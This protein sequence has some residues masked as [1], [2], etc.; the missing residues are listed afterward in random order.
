M[1]VEAA[2]DAIVGKLPHYLIAHFVCMAMHVLQ[3]SITSCDS[4][5]RQHMC[6]FVQAT[7]VPVPA[8]S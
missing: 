5:T 4:L 7:H 1:T 2:R 3:E 8:K 6:G